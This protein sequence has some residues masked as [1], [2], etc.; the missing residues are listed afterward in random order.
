MFRILH[1]SFNEFTG[2]ESTVCANYIDT[3][4]RTFK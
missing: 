3:L 4:I 2:I 1:C